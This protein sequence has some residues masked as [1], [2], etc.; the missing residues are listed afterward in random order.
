M[1]TKIVTMLA[2]VALLLVPY[3]L[4]GTDEPSLS[5][6]D[7]VDMESIYNMSEEA[8]AYSL[9]L[10]E[11][12]AWH[13]K[14]NN[15]LLE[16]KTII[17][18]VVV[19][20]FGT[21]FIGKIVNDD[22]IKLALQKTNEDFKGLN[23]DF[24]DVDTLYLGRRGVLNIEFRL[25]RIAP[26]GESTTGVLYYD[27][28]AGLAKTD[29]AIHEFIESIAWD[30][31][32]YM[33]VYICSDLMDDGATNNSGYAWYPNKYMSDLG[34]ARVVYNGR[35]LYGN[36]DK[37]FS[38]VLTHEFG[39]WLNLIHTFDGGCKAPNDHVDDTPSCDRAAMGCRGA[40]NCIGLFINGE[41]YMDYNAS[42]YKM[43]T[44]G[45]VERMLAALES[46]TRK[47]LWDIENLARTGTDYASSVNDL[48]T[49]TDLGIFPNPAMEYIEIR[50]YSINPTVNRRVDEIAEMKIF[51]T[52][53][54]SVMSVGT[55]R[56]V[57]LQK[58]EI[59]HLPPGVY[60]IRIGSRTLMFVKV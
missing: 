13:I 16:S 23:D 33:N 7:C 10:E 17:I 14:N 18:P 27:D 54:E 49:S 35:Y 11:F 43:F 21:D 48:T 8:R 31:Y 39:H 2:Y 53:G 24:D 51:N 15:S 3:L 26:D 5:A 57:S 19:H 40:L 58:V 4:H 37:E 28:K 1:K 52:L 50:S 46:E 47:P 25:A 22:I 45:Q 34:I 12:T 60:Y 59:S 55:Q 42:C 36:I 6:H 9:Q 30:N 32:K 44:Q 20:V 56:A 29:P 41:N 38:S